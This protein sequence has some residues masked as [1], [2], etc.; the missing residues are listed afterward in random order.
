MNLLH[1][2]GITV[3]ATLASY[4][5]SYEMLSNTRYSA[6]EL[7]PKIE[8][9]AKQLANV[10]TKS[11]D[12]PEACKKLPNKYNGW[13]NYQEHKGKTY[14]ADD[15]SVKTVSRK[16]YT[17][18]SNR[19]FLA[20][21]LITPEEEKKDERNI[22]VGSGVVSGLGFVGFAGMFALDLR[23]QRRRKK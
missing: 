13:F 18:P 14:N 19:D 17:L 23:T 12:I 16:I 21:N 15:G 5:I 8:N 20:D 6:A 9:C 11:H 7:N 3:A 10:A 1:K 22:R 2:T 4:G